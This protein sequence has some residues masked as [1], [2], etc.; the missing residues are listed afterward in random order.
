MRDPVTMTDRGVEMVIQYLLERDFQEI[1][2]AIDANIDADCALTH[3]WIKCGWP[4]SKLMETSVEVARRTFPVRKR[5]APSKRD[6]HIQ[7]AGAIALLVDAG[8]N[9]TRSH[10]ERQCQN[11]SACSLVTSALEQLK[12]PL[13]ER[14]VEGIWAQYRRSPDLRHRG[15]ED[16]IRKRYRLSS[17]RNSSNY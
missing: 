6:H 10:Y 17:L 9:P 16:Y 12:E 3:E 8:F 2:E 5:G 15:S 11:P 4:H 14:R 1:T 7:F 13:G